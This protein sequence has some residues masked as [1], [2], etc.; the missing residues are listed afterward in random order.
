MSFCS[1]A[2]SKGPAQVKSSLRMIQ[3]AIFLSNLMLI[4]TA[5]VPYANVPV[6]KARP[7]QTVILPCEFYFV[8]DTDDL[9]FAWEKE[10]IIEEVEVD[11]IYAYVQQQFDFKEPELLYKFNHKKD[12]LE[13]QSWDYQGRIKIEKDGIPDGVFSLHL[14][15]V[16]FQDEGI[17]K[18]SALNPHGKGERVMKLLVNDAEEPQVQFVTVNDT[19]VAKCISSGWYKTPIITWRNRAERDITANSTMEI[20]E[21]REDGSYRVTTILNYEVKTFEKYYCYIRDAKKERR[22]RTVYRKLSKGL[23]REYG[24]F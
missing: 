13:D 1:Q 19:L 14:E 7:F 10:Q 3:L 8:D 15:N 21:E 18:C 6:V 23:S 17:Y 12:L 9:Y 11:D 4:C 16:G 20:L 22:P 2:R 5:T 24:E